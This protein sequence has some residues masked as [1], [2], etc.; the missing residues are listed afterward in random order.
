[1]ESPKTFKKLTTDTFNECNKGIAT[2]G[3]CFPLN[4]EGVRELN[5]ALIEALRGRRYKEHKEFIKE[6]DRTKRNLCKPL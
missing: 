5:K 4:P 6:D 1:M 2:S 3:F